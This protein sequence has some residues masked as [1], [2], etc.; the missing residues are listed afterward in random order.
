MNHTNYEHF[1]KIEEEFLPKFAKRVFTERTIP[2]QAKFDF[3]NKFL[4]RYLEEQEFRNSVQEL[5]AYFV[6][7]R[8]WPNLG[9]DLEDTEI[10][11]DIEGWKIIT[12]LVT[13]NPEKFYLMNL[14]HQT[15]LS[16][17]SSTYPKLPKAD[18]RIFPTNDFYL[19][20][21]RL[22]DTGSNYTSIPGQE[23]WDYEK[24]RYKNI[25]IGSGRYSFNYSSFNKNIRRIDSIL[26]ETADGDTDFMLLT[27]KEPIFISIGNISP[28]SVGKMIFPRKRIEN[29]NI[30]GF[31][32]ISKHNVTLSCSN[33]LVNMKFQP[34]ELMDGT[35]RNLFE[36]ACL[37][38]R[39]MLGKL[40]DNN[41][42]NNE[43]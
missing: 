10:P 2:D 21:K 27:W 14:G 19:Q 32:V 25:E 1:I 15:D 31:D 39:V 29:L 16:I 12:V 6:D 26:L 20:E 8:F 5:Y 33:G 35:K 17:S 43:N 7:G 41:E 24:N 9:I 34:G 4:I 11:E 28:I 38:K 37:I 13:D 23:N 42:E 30:L 22:I 36:T 18:I 40:E 3:V